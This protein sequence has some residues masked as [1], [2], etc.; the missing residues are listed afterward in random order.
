M[1]ARGAARQKG[2]QNPDVN[3]CRRHEKPDWTFLAWVL[4]Y[5]SS[6]KRCF[7]GPHGFLKEPGEHG[8][9]QAEP[10]AELTPGWGCLGISVPFVTS[11][12]A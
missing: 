7:V 1:D 6:R 9:W 2:T 10:A 3:P 8:S 4:Y 12:R 5:E 11:Q